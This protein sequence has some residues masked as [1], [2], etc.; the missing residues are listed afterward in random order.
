MRFVSC[1]SILTGT[2]TPVVRTDE[3]LRAGREA[4]IFSDIV[5]KQLDVGAERVLSRCRNKAIHCHVRAV[6]QPELPS[7]TGD[8]DI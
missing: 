5:P 2:P 3:V 1:V 4:M 8:S 6:V 7:Q